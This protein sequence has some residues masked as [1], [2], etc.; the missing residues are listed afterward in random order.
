MSKLALIDAVSLE[1]LLFKLGFQ[2]IRQRGSHV[3]YRHPDGRTTTI[4]FHVGMDLPR[5]LLRAILREI[6]ISIDE[7]NNLR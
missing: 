6:N 3:F 7:Y 5:P 2:K 1:K 4:P